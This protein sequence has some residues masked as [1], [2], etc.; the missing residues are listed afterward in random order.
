MVSPGTAR[1]VYPDTPYMPT[2]TPPNHR[3]YGAYNGMSGVYRSHLQ[4]TSRPIHPRKRL[5]F[6]LQTPPVCLGALST[7]RRPPPPTGPPTSSTGPNGQT[8]T[9]RA[10]F[11]FGGGVLCRRPGVEDGCEARG[12]SA[13]PRCGLCTWCTARGVDPAWLGGFWSPRYQCIL[14]DLIW[15]YSDWATEELV[16]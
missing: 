13:Y 3:I 4:I 1:L 7:L 6:L 9:Q 12:A 5:W 11:L 2:L 8:Q 16:S 10:R 15:F 14:L